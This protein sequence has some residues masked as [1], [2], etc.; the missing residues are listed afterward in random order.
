MIVRLFGIGILMCAACFTFIFSLP[1]FFIWP[2]GWHAPAG[3]LLFLLVTALGVYLLSQNR[4]TGQLVFGL[5]LL[6]AGLAFL[7]DNLWDLNLLRFWPALLMLWGL[8]L[9]LQRRTS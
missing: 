8:V 6:F 4:R 5:T 1:F 2:F 9:I 3:W 7:A